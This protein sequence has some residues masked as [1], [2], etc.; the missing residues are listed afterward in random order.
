MKESNARRTPFIV[1]I[2]P[3]VANIV[4]VS[5]RR[6]LRT[7]YSAPGVFSTSIAD[8]CS[9]DRSLSLLSL[10]NARCLCIT[11][12]LLWLDCRLYPAVQV[13][14]LLSIHVVGQSHIHIGTT[15]TRTHHFK[16]LCIVLLL[17]GSS[18]FFLSF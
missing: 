15:C 6:A 3:Q 18:F 14:S 17:Y 16:M 5:R 4:L 9:P 11:A 2:D 13:V 8:A 10:A 7:P 1:R 12:R